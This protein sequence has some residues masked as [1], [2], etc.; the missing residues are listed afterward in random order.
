[1]EVGK[2]E[3]QTLTL[4]LDGS[5]QLTS[6]HV[7]CSVRRKGRGRGGGGKLPTWSSKSTLSP[8][9]LTSFWSTASLSAISA[10]SC[11]SQYC[12]WLTP[13]PHHHTGTQAH[14]HTHSL[15]EQCRA[16]LAPGSS[17]HSQWT[18][19]AS[20]DALVHGHPHDKDHIAKSCTEGEK[21][22]KHMKEKEGRRYETKGE[23]EGKA[24]LYP[25][26]HPVLIPNIFSSVVSGYSRS[27]PIV[28][29][30]RRSLICTP[31][32]PPRWRLEG[33]NGVR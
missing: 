33:D 32:F 26:T 1:M 28:S 9:I 17:S 10:A 21:K 11:S 12:T 6:L 29:I 7:Y 27:C 13:I 20:V 14:T 5:E 30:P 3:R 8:A 19:L 31:S 4:S 15:S 23:N 16:S 24:K 22:R 25:E 2:S 18:E